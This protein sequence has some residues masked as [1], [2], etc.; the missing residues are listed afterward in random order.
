MINKIKTTKTIK[1][2]QGNM[3]ESRFWQQQK[4]KKGHCYSLCIY[5][6]KISQYKI[7]KILQKYSMN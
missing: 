6:R 2:D 5:K 4:E 3:R 7:N 1:A